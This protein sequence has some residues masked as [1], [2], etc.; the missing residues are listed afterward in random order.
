MLE[1]ILLSQHQVSSSKTVKPRAP[2]PMYGHA[3]TTWP[4]VCP[5][6]PHSQF[7]KE[8]RLHLCMKQWNLGAWTNETVQHQS[9]VN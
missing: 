9:A 1:V 2:S 4:A 5:M 8:A 3:I 7:G 6:A